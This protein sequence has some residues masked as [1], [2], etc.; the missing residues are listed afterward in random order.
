MI[1][2]H[3]KIAEPISTKLDRADGIGLLDVHVKRVEVNVDIGFADLVDEAQD[4][5]A[6]VQ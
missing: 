1:L 4:L 3:V 6:R 5:R 2:V